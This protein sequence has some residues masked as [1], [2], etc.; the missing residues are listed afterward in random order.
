MQCYFQL[1]YIDNIKY[2]G[3]FEGFYLFV[4]QEENLFFKMKTCFLNSLWSGC[5]SVERH[6]KEVP[7]KKVNGT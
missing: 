6:V 5:E 2:Q 1:N 4:F 3:C 7:V